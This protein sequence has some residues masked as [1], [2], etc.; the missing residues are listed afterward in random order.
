M[1]GGGARLGEHRNPVDVDIDAAQE[2]R[3][4]QPAFA[5]AYSALAEPTRSP[6]A[7]KQLGVALF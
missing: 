1:R 3:R 4:R 2:Q 5:K 7:A 6:P